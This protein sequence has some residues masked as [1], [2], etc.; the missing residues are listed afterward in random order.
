MDYYLRVKFGDKDVPV[1]PSNLKELTIIQDI[2]KFLPEFRLQLVDTTGALTHTLPFDINMSKVQVEFSPDLEH[3]TPNSLT[4]SIYQREPYADESTPSG[5]YEI[6]GLLDVEGLL[7]PQ[8]SRGFS[9]TIKSTIESI[10]TELRIGIKKDEG[11]AEIEVSPAL[12]E[13]KNLVQPQWNNAQFLKYLKE[14]LEGVSGEY[15]YKCFI[16]AYKTR[17]TFVFKSYWE[18]IAETPSYKFILADTPYEDRLPIINYSIFDNYKIYTTLAGKEQGF[19]YFNYA[20]S[21]FVTG[22]EEIQDYTSLTD[23]WLLDQNDSTD[24]NS[25]NAT[26]RSNDFTSNFGGYVKSSYSNRMMSL[27]QMWITTYGMANVCPGQMVEIFFPYGTEGGE[28]YSY[29]YSGYWLIEK[30]VH[31]FG[32][33]YITRL[34]LTRNGLDTDKATTLLKA[35]K[36]I[37]KSK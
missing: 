17:T 18:M 20:T 13:T 6:V 29:Q 28:M 7:N 9:G 19:A 12:G 27:V 31:N 23:F 14:N 1:N 32:D 2:N 36:Q 24:N 15:G 4:F 25:L 16:K 10:A 26:G 22:T 35:T 34:L 33:H 11:I 37:G 30:V 21:E 5:R 3:E 8:Y